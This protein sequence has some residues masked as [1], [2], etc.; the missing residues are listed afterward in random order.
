MLGNPPRTTLACLLPLL[1]RTEGGNGE[2]RCRL[3]CDAE[4]LPW[5]AKSWSKGPPRPPLRSSSSSSRLAPHPGRG[6]GSPSSSSSSSSVSSWVL[7][8]R[9]PPFGAPPPREA[10]WPHGGVCGEAE[11]RSEQ[12]GRLLLLV[13]L[14]RVAQ[15]LI[16]VE[17]ERRNLTLLRAPGLLCS[18]SSSSSRDDL[19]KVSGEREGALSTLL[20]GS[21]CFSR[22]LQGQSL[23]GAERKRGPLQR[24]ASPPSRSPPP[25]R[26]SR[27]SRF[28]ARAGEAQHVR[29][30]SGALTKRL[31]RI[32][33]MG[34]EAASPSCPES[35]SGRESEEQRRRS[36]LLR[37]ASLLLSFSLPP[38]RKRE[39][40]KG[41]PAD[42]PR[43]GGRGGVASLGIAPPPCLHI[44]VTRCRAHVAN[45]PA[46]E[47]PEQCGQGTKLD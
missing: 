6:G 1:F 7:G 28:P 42:F 46:A 23:G 32:K 5:A 33:R 25:P 11:R 22:P 26:G 43:K 34:W 24:P 12:P 45:A 27:S 19:A 17:E 38:R 2:M 9:A 29:S 10:Q 47:C 21:F 41:T 37:R 4:G 44:G 40:G 13:V 30:G 39:E 36:L 35:F 15:G 16:R 8:P 31:A 18:S 20:R 14:L 3:L